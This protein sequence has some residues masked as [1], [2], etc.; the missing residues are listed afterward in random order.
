MSLC[1]TCT[2]ADASCG[3]YEPGKLV[4]YCTEHR[5]KN[6]PA[7][8]P[9]TSTEVLISSMLILARDIQSGDGVAN[10]AIREAADRLHELHMRCEHL[11]HTLAGWILRPG[12]EL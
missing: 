7:P 5:P 8:A 10:A 4:N 9:R 1:A 2:K 12:K 6:V 3:F 11:E